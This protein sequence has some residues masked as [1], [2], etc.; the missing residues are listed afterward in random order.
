MFEA[1]AQARLQNPFFVLEV[2]RADGRSGLS[3]G[4]L[5]Q[6]REPLWSRRAMGNE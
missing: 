1:H 3:I 2:P 4:M 5:S 6:T